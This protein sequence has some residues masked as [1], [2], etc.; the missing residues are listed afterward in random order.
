MKACEQ[1]ALPARFMVSIAH[2]L[3]NAKL[4]CARHL[5]ATVQAMVDADG[6]ERPVN[7]RVL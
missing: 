7:V 3:C 4:A 5:A 1:C 6:R 2:K